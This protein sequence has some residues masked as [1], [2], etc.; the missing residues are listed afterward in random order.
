M[1]IKAKRRST[2]K[3]PL[4]YDVSDV[5]TMLDCSR[6]YAYNIISMLRKELEEKG[7]IP[8]PAGRIRKSYFDERFYAPDEVRGS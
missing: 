7:Y 4:M 2:V 8:G 5:M 3:K 6:S 1:A